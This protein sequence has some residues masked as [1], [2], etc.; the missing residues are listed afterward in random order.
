MT[1]WR[2]FE[3]ELDAWAE[4]GSSATFWWRDDDAVE[5]TAAL[6]R[7]LALAAAQEVPVATAV[8]PGRS[9]IAL[10][11]RL[12]AAADIAIPLQHGYLHRNHAP[13]GE[14]KAELGDHRPSAQV[15][16]D[17]MRG[18]ARM[19]AILGP[20]ALP[21]LVPP[22]NRIAPELVPMLPELGLTGLSTYGA[23]A[24]SAPVPGLT[25]VNTHVDI[26]RWDAP[27][28]FLGES[29]ALGLFRGHLEARRRAGTGRADA[30]PSEPTG[31]LTHHLAHDEPA[32]EFLER[33]LPVLTRHPAASA[34]PV[35]DVF[36]TMPSSVSEGST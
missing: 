13:A 17:L 15:C 20:G 23:R 24:A 36:N 1:S 2:E 34:I 12:A 18:A 21:V 8:V 6:D 27:R 35:F 32:W 3:Q 5:P 25:Q 29:E 22:W 33:L 19:A 9:C 30:D 26:M 11:R 4:A 7:L 14:K 31:L 28:G 10:G 16:E